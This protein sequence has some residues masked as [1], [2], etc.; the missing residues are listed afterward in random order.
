MNNFFYIYSD[1]NKK[2]LFY[3]FASNKP[4]LNFKFFFSEYMNRITERLFPQET[5]SFFE[6]SA[7]LILDVLNGFFVI[8]KATMNSFYFY[9]WF[10]LLL[11]IFY[12]NYRLYMN[13]KRDYGKLKKMKLLID[14]KGIYSFIFC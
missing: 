11:I 6:S 2:E 7:A 8:F 14:Q 13:Y 5:K 9:I 1:L 3:G 10:T 12:A 4:E